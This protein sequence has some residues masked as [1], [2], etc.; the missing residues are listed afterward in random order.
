MTPF[1]FVGGYQ[2]FGG[3]YCFDLY[4]EDGGSMFLKKKKESLLN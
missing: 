3:T 2:L 4:P 1:T